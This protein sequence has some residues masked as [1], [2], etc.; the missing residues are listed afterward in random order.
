ML[1]LLWATFDMGVPDIKG[2]L[3]SSD[4]KLYLLVIHDITCISN[5]IA[6]TGRNIQYCYYPWVD[7]LRAC[8]NYN[9]VAPVYV[10][11]NDI[12]STTFGGY[13]YDERQGVLTVNTA[14]TGAKAVPHISYSDAKHLKLKQYVWA[15]TEESSYTQE[16]AYYVLLANLNDG[17]VTYEIKTTNELKM[18]RKG[19]YYNIKFCDNKLTSGDGRSFNMLIYYKT[20]LLPGMRC[21]D[22]LNAG[23]KHKNL[24]PGTANS[25]KYIIKPYSSAFIDKVERGDVVGNE[26][27][28]YVY[29]KQYGN[30]GKYAGAVADMD[31]IMSVSANGVLKQVTKAIVFDN[32]NGA[33]EKAITTPLNKL[34][35]YNQKAL[36]LAFLHDIGFHHIVRTVLLV[37]S[38]VQMCLRRRVE[39]GISKT[40]E[41]YK[42]MQNKV[43]SLIQNQARTGIWT[44]TRI[45]SVKEVNDGDKR[46]MSI[47]LAPRLNRAI[48]T[49]LGDDVQTLCKNYCL[50]VLNCLWENTKHDTCENFD[51]GDYVM[52]HTVNNYKL[53]LFCLSVRYTILNP[54]LVMYGGLSHCNVYGEVFRRIGYATGKTGYMQVFR[55][56]NNGRRVAVPS[57]F[58]HYDGDCYKDLV[59]RFLEADM[60]NTK[61]KVA[62]R[63]IDNVINTIARWSIN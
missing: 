16:Y 32:L 27:N 5:D 1:N 14:M 61:A 9:K 21:D 35:T 6:N 20:G 22:V 60:N 57:V 36:R 52:R 43:F 15:C 58:K 51:F 12:R 31:A 54:E 63:F 49:S 26:I 18:K 48:C 24:C 8:G 39:I 2:G 11:V 47:R 50:G 13:Y 37:K 3:V 41:D 45:M 28:R 56:N 46:G 42:D 17:Y 44:H 53:Y 4:N 55:V 33:L 25:N 7:V 59:N 10:G 62:V 29:L 23:I 19:K 30:F 34:T 38:N 40:V